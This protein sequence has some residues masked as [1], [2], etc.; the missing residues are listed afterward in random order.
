ML[1]SVHN[2]N[3]TFVCFCLDELKIIFKVIHNVKVY[4]EVA[5]YGCVK[6]HAKLLKLPH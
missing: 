1:N 5:K 3:L 6:Y 2:E 4:M